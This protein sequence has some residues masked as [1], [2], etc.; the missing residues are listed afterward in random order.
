MKKKFQKI[1]S[2]FSFILPKTVSL[3]HSV[4]LVANET[5]RSSGADDPTDR[6][7]SLCSLSDD[8]T[9]GED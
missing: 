7:C 5:Q 4:I 3:S 8:M 1:C 6:I 9:M 2:T